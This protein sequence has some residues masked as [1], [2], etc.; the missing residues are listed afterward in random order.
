MAV[1]VENGRVS[2]NFMEVSDKRDKCNGTDNKLTNGKVNHYKNGH[3]K[4]GLSNGVNKHNVDRWAPIDWSQFELP[5]PA[6]EGS[7]V[8]VALT[9]I[10]FL[11][12]MILGYLNQLLFTP[13]VA[14]ERN[15]EGYA[16]LY[17]PFEQFFSRY[18]YRRVRHCFNR[19]ITSAPAAEVTVKEW[20]T[21]DYNWSFHAPA[22]EVTVKEWQTSDYNWSFHAPAAEVTVK[23][24]QTSDYNWSFHAPAAE[25]TVKEWQTSDYNWSFHAPAAEVTVKEWQTSD[26]NWSFQFT[27]KERR[28]VNLGSYN[29]LGFA[30]GTGEC[31]DAAAAATRRHGLS[32]CSPRAELGQCEL[33]VDLERTTAEFFGV[34][35]AIVFGMGFATNSLALPGLLG[36]G[37]L[38][39]SD[40]NNHASLILGLRLSRVK[41]RVFKHNDMRHL[42]RLARRAVAE[43]KWRKIVIVVEGIYSMEGSIV[44]LPAIMALKKKY[45]LY[46][47]LDEA[48]S[49]GAM[50]PRGRGVTD[51]WGVDA[52]DVDILMGTFTKSFG[53][54]G[55]YIAGSHRLTSWLRAH[56]H[57]HGYAHSMA[58]A[59]AAQILTSM[60]ALDT[61]PGRARVAALRENTRH[62][63]QRGESRA[64]HSDTDLDTPPGRDNTRHFR[65]RGES[66]ATHSCTDTELEDAKVVAHLHLIERHF[67]QRGES[68]ATHSCTDTELEDAKVVAHLHLIERHFRQRLRSM[69]I[70]TFGHDDSPVVPMLVYTF[71]KMVCTVERLTDRSLATVGVGF[72][73]TP[74][75]KARIRKMVC[76]VERLTDRS[77][78]TVGVGF[79][80]TPLNKA[81]IRKMVVA[82]VG[83]GFPATPLKKARIRFCL[84]A[85]HTRAQLDQ[86]LDAIDEIADELGLRYART[87]ASKTVQ[88]SHE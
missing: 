15:R 9:Q 33:H 63:R 26:Y 46:L 45:N 77:L 20:Q 3:V 79:P 11:I 69:G 55:G 88:Q 68:R 72:P 40:E 47:Y 43:G 23:E 4:N 21:S 58:P 50:G 76:T 14:R 35:S 24:W 65:Q 61:P 80:A 7:M 70:L 1:V 18:V 12:L 19:P 86:C 37:D 39:L 57:A 32:L 78:A 31:A 56:G 85:A 52:R 44:P 60:R 74:L 59:V 73:A 28:C 30:S 48:H 82:S 84:S 42:E 54:A 67:R 36:E 49:I 25:V 34:E 13:K 71:S 66:R 53:A 8:T 29:Y 16:P 62:F 51:Y 10:G 83:V 6:D 81:R 17:N 2:S 38:V 41:V 75:N 87:A 22:A 5:A 64:T 27:G